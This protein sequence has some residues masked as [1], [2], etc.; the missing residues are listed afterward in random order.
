MVPVLVGLAA[1]PAQA[2]EEERR[3]GRLAAELRAAVVEQRFSEVVDYD[4]PAVSTEPAGERS[5]LEQKVFQ[6]PESSAVPI[7]RTPNVDA[8][9]IEL[10]ERGRPT[11]VA[12]V[13]LSKDYPDGAV[14]PVD[15]NLSTTDVRWRRWN[16]EEWDAGSAGSED[17]LPGR[18]QAPLEVMSPYPASVLKLMVG[19]GVLRLVDRGTVRLDDNYTYAPANTSCGAA[20]TESIRVWFD[21]MITYSDN[22]STCALIKMMHDLDVVD[23]L[24]AT[25]GELGLG[26]LQVRG[27]NPTTGGTWVGMSMT[28]LDTARLLLIVSG[29]PGK[30]W[31]TPAGEPVTAGLLSSSSRA[32]FYGKLAEQGLNHALSTTNWCGRSYPAPGIPQRVSSRWINPDDGTVTVDGRVYGQDVRPCNRRAEVTFAH[33]T[34]LTNQAGG[35]AGIVHS[36]PWAP[37]RHYIVVVFTN[38]GLRFGDAYKPADPPGI[39]PVAYTE[40]IGKLGRTIDDIMTRRGFR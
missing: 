10:D 25:F 19:F 39:Y 13:V 27:T 24:N 1:L 33:K 22:R 29:A 5:G 31:K 34:G 7:A 6:A 17:V 9:V 40:R 20:G 26:T 32:F 12:N 38:L 2:T 15:E 4:P 16:T 23:E 14:V 37:K 18:E 30:L 3:G 11:A 8:A 21:R 36:L 35:D 28:A